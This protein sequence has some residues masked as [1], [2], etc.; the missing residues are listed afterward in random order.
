MTNKCDAGLI[1][2]ADEQDKADSSRS[3]NP[4]STFFCFVDQEKVKKKSGGYGVP[5]LL[6]SIE[7]S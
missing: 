4:E 6:E 2:V 3:D 1:R 7:I 5:P